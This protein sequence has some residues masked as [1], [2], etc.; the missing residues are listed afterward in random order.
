MHCLT[1]CFIGEVLG[2]VLASWWGW[3][4]LASVALAIGL[5]F[6]FGYALSLLPVLRAGVAFGA[7]VGIALAADTLSITT[8]EV[9]DNLLMLV[10]PGAM[11]A[12]LGDPW[13][14]G[15]IAVAFFIA[16]WVTVP[17]NCALIARGKG[18]A[19]SHQYMHAGHH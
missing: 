19:V 13:F 15:A 5:A 12:G 11:D 2:L 17:V 16:F 7:V 3:G 8:M 10:L 9:V 18:H 6:V 4:D 14:W 1:G